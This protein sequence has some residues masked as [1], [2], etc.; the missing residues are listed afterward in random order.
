MLSHVG[1]PATQAAL[2]AVGLEPNPA[3]N[4]IFAGDP[5]SF[6]SPSVPRQLH[7]LTG[8]IIPKGNPGPGRAVRL[9]LTHP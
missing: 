9:F 4:E 5:S 3:S 2:H 6:S 1:N 7:H 8:T